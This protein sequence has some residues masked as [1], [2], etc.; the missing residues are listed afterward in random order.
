MMLYAVICQEH[1]RAIFISWQEA[2][3]WMCERSESH[4]YQCVQMLVTE[5]IKVLNLSEKK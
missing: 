1:V 4:K 3:E 2:Q 5:I